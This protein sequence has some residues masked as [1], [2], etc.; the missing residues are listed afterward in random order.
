MTVVRIRRCLLAILCAAV[1]VCCSQPRGIVGKWR[2]LD[3]NMVW[4]F[5]ADGAITQ[6]T[7]R[8]RYSFGD[9]QRVKIETPV[10]TS[11]YRTQLA[12]DRLTL[13]DPRGAKL[14]FN[15]VKESDR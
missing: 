9:N 8:G 1:V 11:V 14:E 7:M 5:T 15:R 10:A 6:G 2:T 13:I 12:E 3:G 4:E